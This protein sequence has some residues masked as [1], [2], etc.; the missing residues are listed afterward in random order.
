[1]R[2]FG[3]P[4]YFYRPGYP[5]QFEQEHK[6][7][8]ES[9]FNLINDKENLNRI[10]KI[11][12]EG[13]NHIVAAFFIKSVQQSRMAKNN[14]NIIQP[15]RSSVPVNSVNL[16]EDGNSQ[17]NNFNATSDVKDVVSNIETHPNELI[18]NNTMRTNNN[19]SVNS[20]HSDSPKNKSNGDA[21]SIPQINKYSIPN[22]NINTNIFN[23]K[24]SPDINEFTANQLNTVNDVV[25][26]LK[27]N[28]IS[29]MI[30]KNYMNNIH[31][32]K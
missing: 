17:E 3:M 18:E 20:A 28:K 16:N 9:I 13:V 30:D 4:D 2:L 27:E 15:R 25:K 11:A 24:Y 22:L 14:D 26:K 5:T 12:N 29:E 31:S 32:K 1:M 7:K 8:S 10:N 23:D 19:A 21:G 6:P